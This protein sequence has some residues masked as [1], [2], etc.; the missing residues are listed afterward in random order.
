MSVWETP[1][2]W[3]GDD[4]QPALAELVVQLRRRAGVVGIAVGGSV[5][6]G[7]ARAGSDL[8]ILVL[9]DVNAGTPS[10]VEAFRYAGRPT[11]VLF[12]REDA[13][14]DIVRDEPGGTQTISTWAGAR[15]LDDTDGRLAGLLAALEA[16][17]RRGP[18]PLTAEERDYA[19]FEMEHARALIGE[20][21]ASSAPT[22]Q[23]TCHLLIAGATHIA[24]NILLRRAHRWPV[25][26]RQTLR[27]LRALDSAAAALAER[28]LAAPNG[29]AV[30]AAQGLLDHAQRALDGPL[31]PGP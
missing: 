28:A 15:I 16:R 5:A 10:R 19:L 25:G 4:E 17:Y 24:A 11:E 21:A 2:G 23:A 18:S 6:R 31:R 27:A 9:V 29:D 30:D 12:L 20:A 7:A 8:D 14:R 13:L 22:E 3:A 26:W 1:T